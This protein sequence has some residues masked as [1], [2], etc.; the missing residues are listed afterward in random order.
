[1]S[2]R[3][4][5]FYVAGIAVCVA[6]YIFSRLEVEY[7][8]QIDFLYEDRL[9]WNAQTRNDEIAK[10]ADEHNRNA[11]FE[12]LVHDFAK[13]MSPFDSL[14]QR[15]CRCRED[16]A[17][18]H[19]DAKRIE[20]VLSTLHFDVIERPTSNFVFVCRLTVKDGMRR[21]LS[22]IAR[23]CMDIA[24]EKVLADNQVNLWRCAYDKFEPMRRNERRIDELEEISKKRELE[25]TEKDELASAKESV[26]RLRSAIDA[27]EQKMRATRWGRIR[28]RSQPRLCYHV[29]M[30]TSIG[31]DRVRQGYHSKLLQ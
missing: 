20:R 21:N 11:V 23:V 14:E 31:A 2:K 30:K 4:A 24:E 29:L 27:I 17:L 16:T 15:V 25:A 19:E 6:A 13:G 9:V 5:M 18:A 28:N 10:S 26:A 12:S 8:C 7:E 22:E 3:S 1:M